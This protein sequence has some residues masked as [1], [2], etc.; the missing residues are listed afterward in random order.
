MVV[1]TTMELLVSEKG[2]VGEGMVIDTSSLEM[3]RK[4]MLW[5]G[6][7]WSMYVFILN[8]QE[9]RQ[10]RNKHFIKARRQL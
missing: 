7:V 1:R 6:W 4:G 10:V 5:W 9:K 2:D 3:D 8:H